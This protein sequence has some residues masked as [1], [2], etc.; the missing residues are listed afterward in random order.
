MHWFVPPRAHMAHAKHIG[1]VIEHFSTGG[2]ER[3][4]ITLA[5]R[6]AASGRDVTIYCA[7]EEG[8]V[9]SLV[10]RDVAVT[11][12]ANRPM[13]RAGFGRAVARVVGR[14]APDVLVGPGNHHIPILAGL[15]AAL[16]ARRPAIVAK[17][18][19]PI[20]RP[21]RSRLGQALFEQGLR[22]RTARFDRVV[23]MS[24]LLADEASAV[25]RR[26]NVACLAEPTLLGPEV[27][28][29]HRPSGL[30]LA[31]GRL[32]PQKDFGLALEAFARARCDS[33]LVILGE[34][35]DY[36]AL[37]DRANALGLGERVRFLGFVD[38][39][40]PWLAAADALLC[41][42]RFE[43]YPAALVEA[44]AAGVPVV[45]TPCSAA[46]PEF[47]IDGSCGAIVPADAD[48]L[49]VALDDVLGD[50]RAPSAEARAMLRRRHDADAAARAWL[51][52]LDATVAAKRGVDAPNWTRSIAPGRRAVAGAIS[53]AIVPDVVPA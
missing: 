29:R 5:N 53:P 17:L 37:R 50:A 28:R 11:P 35:E 1:L 4:A 31:I 15:A 9:R 21:G 18:S 51:A 3:V 22:M 39:V 14:Q 43:G 13:S 52:M 10:S 25:L 47:M 36:G 24:P 44:L 42:S 7:S 16:P 46:L 38:D 49:A 12:L 48:A 6:W 27:A 19:N 41:T 8:L 23:A 33:R 26:R 32:A 40:A 30:V 45:T 34:G 2:S 20:R